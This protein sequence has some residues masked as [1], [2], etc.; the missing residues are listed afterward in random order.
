MLSKENSF[1]SLSLGWCWG[2]SWK[3]NIILQRIVNKLKLYWRLRQGQ[4]DQKTQSH[5]EH[6]LKEAPWCNT[7]QQQIIHFFSIRSRK[8]ILSQKNY[9][10]VSHQNT[11][12]MF[13][14]YCRAKNLFF[15][16]FLQLRQVIKMKKKYLVKWIF[17]YNKYTQHLRIYHRFC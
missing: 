2:W 14:L 13:L 11:F 6:H 12:Q 7:S 1:S 10:F 5:S 9:E 4:K 16:I 8:M 15:M 3:A 17:A